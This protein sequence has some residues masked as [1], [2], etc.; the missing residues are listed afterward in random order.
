MV[1]QIKGSEAEEESVLQ[2]QSPGFWRGFEE[3]CRFR[4]QN[5]YL[6]MKQSK[7]FRSKL[8]IT[9]YFI[10]QPNCRFYTFF[11]RQSWVWN[12]KPI[13]FHATCTTI[14]CWALNTGDLHSVLRLNSSCVD[15]DGGLKLLLTEEAAH[16]APPVYKWCKSP[17]P[18]KKLRRASIKRASLSAQWVLLLPIPFCIKCFHIRASV[19]WMFY[20]FVS[21]F[22]TNSNQWRYSVFNMKSSFT[23]R[24]RDE[25]RSNELVISALA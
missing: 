15:T 24:A 1:E 17:Q 8:Q 20:C 3:S 21:F 10:M 22:C 12:L 2:H 23:T 9:S 11:E 16:V 7:G 19:K 4:R 14:M 6:K 13:I 18:R 25:M 5:Y